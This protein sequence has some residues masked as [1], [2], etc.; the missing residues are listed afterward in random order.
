MLSTMEEST[1]F[2]VTVYMLV[3]NGHCSSF[4]WCNVVG[5]GGRRVILTQDSANTIMHDI[6]LLP[7]FLYAYANLKGIV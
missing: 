3:F 6:V 2:D 5:G 4:L 7:R 1:T